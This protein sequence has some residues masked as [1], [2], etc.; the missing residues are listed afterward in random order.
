MNSTL[1]HYSK[2]L[3]TYINDSYWIK[4]ITINYAVHLTW[5]AGTIFQN[6]VTL[7]SIVFWGGLAIF[8]LTLYQIVSQSS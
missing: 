4:F 2:K 7:S 6:I 5:R 3:I 1:L 8:E